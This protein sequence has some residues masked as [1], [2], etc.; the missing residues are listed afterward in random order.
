MGKKFGPREELVASVAVM[1]FHRGNL[2]FVFQE[3]EAFVAAMEAKPEEPVRCPCCEKLV[4]LCVKHFKLHEPGK[5]CVSCLVDEEM[6][7]S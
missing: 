6:R 1:K 2:G 3:S 5:P 7:S 4:V